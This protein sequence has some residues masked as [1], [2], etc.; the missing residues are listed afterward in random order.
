MNDY[1]L[2]ICLQN[3]WPTNVLWKTRE[4][5]LVIGC[6]ICS[7]VLFI[8]SSPDC[9]VALIHRGFWVILKITIA[10]LYKLFHDIMS[11]FLP[12]SN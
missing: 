5:E 12:T 8:D 3:D 2:W 11:L 6:K 10:N 4:L 9:F 7:E 1:E